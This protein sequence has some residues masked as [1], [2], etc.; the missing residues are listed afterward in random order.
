[1]EINRIRRI[2]NRYEIDLSIITPGKNT[3]LPQVVTYLTANIEID[4]NI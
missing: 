3:I 1:M 2:G 4:K